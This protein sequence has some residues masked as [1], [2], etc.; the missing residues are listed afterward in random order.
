M[1]EPPASPTVVHPSGVIPQGLVDKVVARRGGRLH[2]YDWLDGPRTAFVVVDLDED[3]CRR[4][5]RAHLIYDP[6]NAVAAAVR[7]AGGTVAFVTTSIPSPDW[8][9]VSL[10]PALAASYYAAA[11]SGASTRLAAELEVG[12]DDVRAKKA[13]ASAFFPD[14]CDLH[15]QL[16]DLDIE[17]VL[18]GGLVTNV[19]CESSARD[20]HELGYE[21]T[22]VSDALI[23]HSWGLHEA[24][25]ATF[26]RIFGDVRP[27]HE[28]IALLRGWAVA[29]PSR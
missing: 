26:F 14:N 3:S 22:M 11:A 13:R 7:A 9:A 19:C 23:G 5:E 1:S 15:F 12:P 21:V 4:S 25:L 8:L 2:M 29:P 6:V 10:G 28:V 18:I 24:S 27:S 16:R 17:H 20:A